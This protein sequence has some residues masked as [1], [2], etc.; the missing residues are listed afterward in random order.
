LHDRT[1]EQVRT[2]TCRANEALAVC[3][4]SPADGFSTSSMRP[5]LTGWG[6][7]P[8]DH[9]LTR[10]QDVCAR[11]VPKN[12]YWQPA[13]PWHRN[14]HSTP[15]SEADSNHDKAQKQGQRSP[16]MN[17]A[18][19]V[20][21]APNKCTLSR[22]QRLTFDRPTRVCLRTRLQ[23]ARDPVGREVRSRSLQCQSGSSLKAR[24]SRGADIPQW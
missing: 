11:V 23:M 18:G 5:D 17:S 24:Q 16:R 1:Q 7:R 14:I 21:T 20:A 4:T 9:P 15:Q 3:H 12:R 8:S 2:D 22:L 13:R 10:L 19:R 6:H